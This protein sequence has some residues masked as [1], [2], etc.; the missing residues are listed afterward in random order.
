MTGRGL[1]SQAGKEDCFY[2]P[3]K[4]DGISKSGVPSFIQ[5]VSSTPIECNLKA[6][7]PFSWCF[8]FNT[9]TM[10]CWEQN[11]L[12]EWTTTSSDPAIPRTDFWACFAEISVLWLSGTRTLGQAET[13]VPLTQNLSKNWIPES[14]FSCSPPSTRK[15]HSVP[16]LFLF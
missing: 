12:T 2:Q 13:L 3:G 9:K 15:N 10:W 6:P 8:S 11:L 1:P 16:S 7:I 5:V 14:L 4:Y